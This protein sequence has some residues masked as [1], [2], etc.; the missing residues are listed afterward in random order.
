[1]HNNKCLNPNKCLFLHELIYDK[2]IILDNKTI[3]SYNEH[4][5]LSK[6]IIQYFNPHTK[7]IIRNKIKPK[8]IK[9]PFI[10]F[11]FLKEEEKEKYFKSGNISYVRGNSEEFNFKS[12]N[13]KINQ[14]INNCKDR[15]I[16]YEKN[17]NDNLKFNTFGFSDSNININNNSN[18]SDKINPNSLKSADLQRLIE[19]SIK[20]IMEVK[21]F[22]SKLN[23]YPLKKLELDYFKEELEKSGSNLFA[24]FGECLDCLKDVVA[25]K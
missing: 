15:N 21:P 10:D 2:D 18:F 3:F 9:F 8:V 1:M 20:H 14:F 6:K 19:N 13:V 4:L 24:I 23:N 11:I 7:D 12:Y 16:L 22:Y 17:V 25:H 5:N